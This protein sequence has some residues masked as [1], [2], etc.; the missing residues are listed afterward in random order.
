MQ[1]S[2]VYRHPKYYALGYRWNTDVECDFIESCLKT[3][4]PAGAKRLLDIGCGAG[5]HMFNLAQRGYQM[6]GIDPSPEM[7][8]YVQDGAKQ[9][10]LPVTVSIGDLRNLQVSG[11]FDA[12]Y[13]FMDTFRF[14][15]T[16]DEIRAHLQAVA[17]VLAPGGLYLTDFWVPTRW[18]Q[19]GSEIHQWEQTEGTT[20]VRVFYL[21]HPDSVDPVT[22]TFEDEL[23][24]EIHEGGDIR[25]IRGGPTR[26]RLILPLEFQSLVE[27][28][29]VFELV[30][31]LGTFDLAAP[32]SHESLSWRMVSVLKKR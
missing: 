22:Q 16:N 9:L 20:T 7:I 26:T 13:C 11:T 30:T 4:A 5:R 19:I 12:A 24:F 31:S 32:F 15:L 27:A 28:S 23:V 25:E 6:T 3:Y 21:Q 18:D 1:N 10:K 2:E 14:L 17:N 29:G 8:A